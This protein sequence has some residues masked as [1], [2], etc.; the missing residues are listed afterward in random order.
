[1][2]NTIGE[3]LMCHRERHL[4]RLAL[5]YTVANLDDVNEC[6]TDD[7]TLEGFIKIY[8]DNDSEILREAQEQ[9]LLELIDLFK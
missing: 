5:N 4:V 7:D 6:M 2:R 9:E 1:M 8:N 3:G